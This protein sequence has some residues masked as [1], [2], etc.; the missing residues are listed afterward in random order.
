M[1]YRFGGRDFVSV[2]VST[3][4]QDRWFRRLCGEAGLLG[5]VR[6]EGEPDD[7]FA[8]RLLQAIDD[9]GKAPL[10]LGGLL[11]PEGTAPEA[12]TPE[13]AQG[14]ADHVDRLADPEEKS[15]AYAVLLALLLLFF[16]NGPRFSL[17]SPIS[18]TNP[19]M[20]RPAGRTTATAPG[21]A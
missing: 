7:D 15:Q 10:L 19:A 12:W 5:V 13:T 8:L 4:K 18:S 6:G 20:V 9:S 2:G 11:V 21:A 17:R 3:L 1:Q 16:P 14:T